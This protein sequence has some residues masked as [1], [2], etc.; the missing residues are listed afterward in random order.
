MR[1]ILTE[2]LMGTRDAG[3]EPGGKLVN[4]SMKEE[5][6]SLLETTVGHMRENRKRILEHCRSVGISF[7]VSSLDTHGRL[8]ERSRARCQTS[9]QYVGSGLPSPS[10]RSSHTA[11]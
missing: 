7:A 11:V 3:L 9:A 1:L 2:D 4:L 10:P 8:R 6:F 5:E